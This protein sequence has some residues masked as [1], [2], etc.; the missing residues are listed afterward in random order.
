LD[1]KNIMK[2]KSLLIYIILGFLVVAQ[3]AELGA[4]DLCHDS[5]HEDIGSGSDIG[6]GP[7][8]GCCNDSLNETDHCHDP[9][10]N[11]QVF[12]P[13]NNNRP[14]FELNFA[15]LFIGEIP[16][17]NIPNSPSNIHPKNLPDNLPDELSFKSTI[18]LLI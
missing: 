17:L 2:H 1:L 9:H 14:L 5:H 4:F 7:E 12:V 13:S 18:V 8:S 16:F 10:I 15:K 11:L 3:G 6:S